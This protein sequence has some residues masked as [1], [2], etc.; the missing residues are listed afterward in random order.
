MNLNNLLSELELDNG[1]FSDWGTGKSGFLRLSEVE[2][3]L[4][5]LLLSNSCAGG[6][7]N[8]ELVELLRVPG[9]CDSTSAVRWCSKC[10]AVV[11]DLDVDGRVAPGKVMPMR[12]PSLS[13]FVHNLLVN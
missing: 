9:E 7:G 4:K 1:E 8:H 12:H 13:K 11:I 2:A 5:E 6:G 10:G 3:K